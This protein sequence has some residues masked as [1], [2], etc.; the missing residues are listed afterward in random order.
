MLSQ[1]FFRA[2][3]SSEMSAKKG[4]PYLKFTTA[5]RGKLSAQKINRENEISFAPL[6]FGETDTLRI[7]PLYEAISENDLR[8]G[9]G[10]SYLIRTDSAAILFDLGN[11]PQNESPSPLE[12]NMSLKDISLIDLDCII[13]SHRHPDHVGGMKWWSRKSF[14]LNGEVQND[15]S[16][17]PV[18]TPEKLNYPGCKPHI[19]KNPSKIAPG[20]ATTGSFTFFES[21][22]QAYIFPRDCEQSLAVH[23]KG[24]GIFLIVGCGHMG[25]KTLLKRAKA[26]FNQPI[27][28]IIGGLHY[29]KLKE[30]DL[31]EE[32]QA[33]KEIQPVLIALSPH[34]SYPEALKA[35]ENAFPDVYKTIKVGE[36]ISYL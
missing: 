30:N 33:L 13:F 8:C 27:A 12:N 16:N 15:L 31:Q 26:L 14:S 29:G 22:P 4:N 36:E 23:V 9:Y 7:L 25:L 19:L 34:D 20:V 24:R 21:Y 11:N 18:Y 6:D 1:I 2:K 17:I 28:G 3:V 10:V 5:L 32:I 35:F